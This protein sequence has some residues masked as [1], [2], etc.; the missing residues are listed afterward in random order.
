MSRP[1]DYDHDW[2]ALPRRRGCSDDLPVEE[3]R[4]RQ[5]RRHVVLPEPGNAKE[6]RWWV[7]GEINS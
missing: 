2:D 7:E 3:Q 4:E 6:Q 1:A 5:I